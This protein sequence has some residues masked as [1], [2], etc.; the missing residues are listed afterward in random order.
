MRDKGFTLIELLVVIAI[1]GLLASTVLAA[2]QSARASGRDA[3]RIMQIKE[4]EKALELYRAKNGYYPQI[5]H[6]LGSETTCGTAGKDWGHCDRLH[7]LML[8]LS[9]Y[10]SIPAE[11]LSEATQGNYYYSYTSQSGDGWQTFGLMVNLETSAG[12]NDGGYVSTA[13]EVGVGPRYCA[14]KYT[15]T[16]R[17]WLN[18]PIDYSRRCAGGN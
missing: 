7:E 8:A 3:A 1:I 10:L 11:S 13:Y 2:L 9:P 14:S 5:L 16:D 4:I 17:D 6:G 15:G 18:K 12:A